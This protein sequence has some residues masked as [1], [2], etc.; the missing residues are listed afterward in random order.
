MYIVKPSWL[1]H[2]DDQ[3]KFEVYSV[4]VSPDNQRV[5][6]GGQDG[7]VRIWSAQSIRDSAK[8]DN[9]TSEP[10]SN[11]AGA[12]APG[13]KQLCS[14][15][16]HNGAVTVVR[17]SPDGR[18]LAT[19]SDDRV[20]LVWERDSTKVPRKE[21]GSSGEADTES[22]IV[23]KRLAAHDNDIQDLAWAPD[24]SILVT[25]GLD[26]GVIVW[27]G[28]TFE[29]IQR[30]DAHNSHVKGITFDPANKFFATASD[31]RT[32][33]IFRYNR[34]SATDVTFSTEATI[35]S[36]FKQSPLSTYF[37][38][39]SWSPDGNHIAAANATNGPVSVVAIINRGTW[40]SDIS[41]IGHEAP[42]EV[43]AF[44][45][46]IFARTKEAAEKKEKK[47]AE[48]D[49]DG[50]V[51]DVDA[52][53]KAPE[54]VPITVIASA[55]QDKT[56]TI[57]NTSNPR[58][59]VVCHDMALKTITDLAWS[60]DGMSLF[61]T[62][63]DGSISYVQFEE[64]EL[65]YVVSME[66][67][68]SR[69]TR[70]GGGKE[71]AQIPESVEQLV[72]EEKV[73]AKEVKDSEKR[74]EELMGAG[75]GSKAIASGAAVVPSPASTVAAAAAPATTARATTPLTAAT[76]SPSTPAK[77]T[78][79]KVTI[80]KDGRKR[81]APQL[82][83]TTSSSVQGTLPAA[84]TSAAAPV[85]S[86]T[87]ETIPVNDFSKPSYALPK[88]G[89]STLVIGSK[90]RSDD[91]EDGSN[92]IQ[93]ALKKTRPDDDVPEYI[94]PVVVS[95]ATTTSQ[96]RLGAPKVRNLLM[97]SMTVRDSEKPRMAN[98]SVALANG[99]NTSSSS[100][101]HSFNF[102]VRNGSGNE[103]T[104]TKVSVTRNSQVVFVDFVPYYVHL[105]A[106][107]GCYF[108]ATSAEDG[109]IVVYSPNGR[110]MLPPLVTGAPLSFLESQN[111][112]LL[113]ISSVGMLY[114]W[115]VV[116]RKA[117]F[118]PV[119]LAPILDSGSRY[120]DGGV[121]R[122]PHVTQCGVTGS[123]RVIITLSTGCGYTY[124]EGLRS[125]CRLSE[126]WWAT[127][128]QYWS[129][130]QLLGDESTKSRWVLAVEER[131]A[132]EAQRRAG[133]RG[134]YL[135]QLTRATLNRE[136][137]EGMEGVVSIAHLE[138]RIAA[139]EMLESKHEL[140]TFIIM[141]ARRIAEE[142]LR[143]R[144]DELCRELLGPGKAQDSN[145]SP[146]VCGLDKHELLKE[147]VLKIGKYRESQRVA[148]VYGQAI[149]LLEDEV[150]GAGKPGSKGSKDDE[151]EDGDHDMT[152]FKDAMSEQ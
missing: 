78:K 135:K 70:Y 122:G 97:R 139:A 20:V 115:N 126:P 128:S 17:F 23:R 63:L 55:G 95:P 1:C 33:Q 48:K 137:Y 103:Q 144:V 113:A 39:C 59:V 149:G 88:G 52:E 98:E 110:R 38:R 68:E 143:S 94:A 58:P 71:A 36:P 74:M 22:W 80:T 21:F 151:D 129:A 60:Q 148:V 26:S 14:M 141:Y 108:W 12:P 114:L 43:A 13:A 7:K 152:D 145:W 40:D 120:E 61:A 96:V 93:T 131:T 35:T 112:Y 51:I 27:S 79:Q 11:V 41:L 130:T 24:S 106:G 8:G 142:G 127:G 91:L 121:L 119:S 29:K 111:E 6:T 146:T 75:A 107:N 25:V 10:P 46:R 83:T 147:V 32:V 77:P 100:A 134:R 82:L 76:S 72:L 64:G 109:S 105:I 37:R 47:S 118:P 34:A 53:P 138:N 140:R 150:L 69:L 99:E 86:A 90:R 104:P 124:D 116:Q 9:E 45:P 44:C 19:G 102:E 84:T 87:A 101:P 125:W 56:L 31:D 16:T 50:S 28:T 62:S 65:G 73:E 42:C 123:G 5:A 133:G 57:W 3:K 92:G 54:S 2:S 67:N 30:L 49:K 15:A 136:G 117:V 132:E 89:V 85:S 66:E 81:V 4:T 18:Y